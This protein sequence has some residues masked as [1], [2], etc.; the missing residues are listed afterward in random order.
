MTEDKAQKRLW[1]AVSQDIEYLRNI[2][3]LINTSLAARDF[4]GDKSLI[5]LIPPTLGNPLPQNSLPHS[6]PQES[7]RNYNNKP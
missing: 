1:L 6:Y 7:L 3:W 2:R 4:G 5:F